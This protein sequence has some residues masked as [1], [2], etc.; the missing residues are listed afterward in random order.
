MYNAN[1]RC[2][3]LP[4][5]PRQIHF[6]NSFGLGGSGEQHDSIRA[7]RA[8][9]PDPSKLDLRWSPVRLR[10]NIHIKCGPRSIMPLRYATIVPHSNALPPRRRSVE[11][12]LFG[13]TQEQKHLHERQFSEV[14]SHCTHTKCSRL[15]LYLHSLVMGHFSCVLILLVKTEKRRDI[16]PVP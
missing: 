7:C 11:G 1:R 14:P 8:P 2:G 3:T 6:L 15:P 9:R 16:Q 5:G 12:T 13:S 10:T 4:A